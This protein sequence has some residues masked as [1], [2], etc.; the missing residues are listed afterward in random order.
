[1]SKRKYNT[2]S[3]AKRRMD[4]NTP[5][6]QKNVLTLDE[7]ML[8]RSRFHYEIVNETPGNVESYEARDFDVVKDMSGMQIGDESA[9]KDQPDGSVI[10]MNVGG[11]QTALVM[12][13][14]IKWHKDDEAKEEQRLQEMESTMDA[15][16]KQKHEG[17]F[18]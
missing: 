14:P 2:V 11:G 5:V 3:R 9:N 6:G 16:N 7:S 4:A 15:E 1:M 12:S 18:G 8:D 17:N 13:K 10:R